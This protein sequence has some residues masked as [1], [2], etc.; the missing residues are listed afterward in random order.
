MPA[1]VRLQQ[2]LIDNVSTLCRTGRTDAARMLLRQAL[3]RNSRDAEAL[4][5][6]AQIEVSAGHT[7]AAAKLLQELVSYQLNHAAAHF[8]LAEITSARGDYVSAEGHYRTTIQLTPDDPVPAYNFGVMLQAL[9]RSDEAC[10]QY[11]Q[12]LYADPRLT[13]AHNNLGNLHYAANRLGEAARCYEQALAFDATLFEAHY[14]LGLIAEKQGNLAAAEGHFRD[15]LRVQ[16]TFAPAYFSMGNVTGLDRYRPDVAVSWYE[17]ALALRPA[18]LE[19]L[20]NLGCSHEKLGQ[21]DQAIE[22]YYK[23]LALKQD[24]PTARALFSDAH[25]NLGQLLYKKGRIAEWV[26][27]FRRFRTA[28]GTLAQLALYGTLFHFFQGEFVAEEACLRDLL[29]HNFEHREEGLL[30]ATISLALYCEVEPEDILGLYRQYDRLIGN[31]AAEADEFPFW[32]HGRRRFAQGERWRIG[33]LSADFRDHVMGRL[34]LP[35][36]REH[37]RDAFEVYCY[38]LGQG[39]DRYTDG[40]RALARK[41][42]RLPADPQEAARLIAEDELDLLVEL[43]GHTDKANPKILACKPAPVQM[44]H[45][46]YHGGIGLGSVDFKLSDCQVDRPE[47]QAYLIETLLPKEGCIFPFLSP[48]E[49]A[50]SPRTRESYGLPEQAVLVGVFAA[51]K[52]L[53]QRSLCAWQRILSGSNDVFL[54]FSPFLAAERTGVLHRTRAVGIPEERV[55]F[56]PVEGNGLTDRGRYAVLDLAFDTYPYSGGDTTLAALQM[57]VP[58]VTWCGREHRERTTTSI[59]RHLGLD[60]LVAPD[61]S[62]YIELALRLIRDTDARVHL[63]ARIL[64]R[65]ASNVDAARYA[66]ELEGVYRHALRLRGPA[67]PP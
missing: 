25:F 54:V 14:N 46:G 29:R 37:D 35:V 49:D 18:Y 55:L 16:P 40:F 4:F 58:V 6:L 48:P 43:A 41:F 36:F 44:T 22:Y 62:A 57:G 19:A 13:Q 65:Y 64:E 32:R 8:G 38:A 61:E 1:R 9:G 47:N 17:K 23:V 53:S 51:M 26:E 11:R 3:L 33:Y 5:L 12:A 67:V 56:I 24:N 45:L 27:N 10:D 39:E 42:T 21:A 30:E 28:G 7:A 20:Y 60:E 66:R 2:P 63:R 50:T 15:T 59:L 52:K 34:M 31:T